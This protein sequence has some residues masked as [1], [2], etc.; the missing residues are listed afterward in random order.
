MESKNQLSTNNLI[1]SLNTLVMKIPEE[2]FNA[3]KS[4]YLY[5]AIVKSD[6]FAEIPDNIE[7]QQ[8][9]INTISN[10]IKHEAVNRKNT[11]LTLNMAFL[12]KNRDFAAERA[13]VS[14]NEDQEKQAKEDETED[15]ESFS[16]ASYDEDEDEAAEENAREF[17]RFIRD[18]YTYAPEIEIVIAKKIESNQFLSKM[19]WV[20]EF[21]LNSIF[22]GLEFLRNTI[23][24]IISV[25]GLDS[26][27]SALSRTMLRYKYIRVLVK[28]VG[29]LIIPVLLI[30]IITFQIIRW[31]ANPFQKLIAWLSR[32]LKIDFPEDSAD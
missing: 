23:S 9:F 15:E 26:Y 16:E 3:D 8:Y 2:F 13:K 14:K 19:K 22:R 4:E 11:L 17:I 20:W 24:S 21:L 5:R 6:F 25:F 27:F 32:Q 12:L 31:T 30:T 7:K 1:E 18:K 28:A 29:T 10:E